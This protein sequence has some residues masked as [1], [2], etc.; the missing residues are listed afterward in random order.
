MSVWLRETNTAETLRDVETGE[1]SLGIIRYQSSSDAYYRQTAAAKGLIMEP[2][3]DFS[4]RLLFS[5]RHPLAQKKEIDSK[6]LMPYI[7]IAHGDGVTSRKESSE[8]E[9]GRINPAKKI[10]VFE[11]GS[12]FDLL[13][14]NHSAYMWVS[15]MPNKMLK[16]YHLIE[17][18]CNGDDR[19]FQDSL[20][21][22]K[23]YSLTSWEKDFIKELESSEYM[24]VSEC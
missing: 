7:E 8:K 24:H 12:Q 18:K 16:R 23:G 20:I 2:L 14:E 6:D 9:T 4:L 21:Y 3:F 11:R 19:I 17:R 22:R 5:S 1:Y 13:S 10:Y 15:P